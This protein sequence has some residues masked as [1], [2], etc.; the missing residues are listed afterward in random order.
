MKQIKIYGA[1]LTFIIIS[2]FSCQKPGNNNSGQEPGKDPDQEQPKPEEPGGTLTGVKYN[3]G[4][5][6]M[7]YKRQRANPDYLRGVRADFVNAKAIK[8]IQVKFTW[9]E[10][11][12]QMGDY[13]W[14]GI[15]SLLNLVKEYGKQL[16]ILLELKSF[17][18][19][20]TK[21]LVP[22]YALNNPDF[23][24]GIQPYTAYG[25]TDKKG[26]VIKI[27]NQNVF[28]RFDSLLKKL[29]KRYNHEPRFEG[30]GLSESTFQCYPAGTNCVSD[31]TFFQELMKLNRRLK[32]YFPN[33]LTYQF[34]NYPRSQLAFQAGELKDM[35]SGWAGPDVFPTDEGLINPGQAYSY[36]R[37]L[38]GIIPLLPS[39]QSED[40]T[41]TRHDLSNDPCCGHVPTIEELHIYARDSLNANYIFWERAFMDGVNYFARVLERLNEPA[42]RDAPA[43]GLDAA[44]PSSYASRGGCITY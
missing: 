41:W 16:V 33:S 31:A 23:G 27:W 34:V 3:P 44:C 6:W 35:G 5:Y 29:G 20:E 9:R 37:Q 26:D 32:A 42:Q 15:D 10:L 24:G 30:I 18:T 13:N 12:N 8:G 11:E 19:T 7:I 25:G 2:F 39:V 4:H 17:H 22:D 1:L 36:Y 14:T 38:S 28:N 40:Y 21:Y 43:G